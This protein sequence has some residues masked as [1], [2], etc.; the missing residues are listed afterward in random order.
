MNCSIVCMD[1]SGGLG[2]KNL[3]TLSKALLGKWCLRFVI[4]R[5]PLGCL[6]D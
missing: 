3:S 1:K 2:I 4:E 5:G 6:V